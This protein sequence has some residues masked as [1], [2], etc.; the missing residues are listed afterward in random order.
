MGACSPTYRHIQIISRMIRHS[1]HSKWFQKNVHIY[2]SGSS[3]SL[4]QAV[5]PRAYSNTGFDTNSCHL[6]QFTSKRKKD[7]HYKKGK[8]ERRCFKVPEFDS[9]ER[10]LVLSVCV[11]TFVLQKQDRMLRDGKGRNRD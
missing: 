5:F 6:L 10:L 3:H 8:E 4:C 7:V 2:V 9:S 11:G 1:K